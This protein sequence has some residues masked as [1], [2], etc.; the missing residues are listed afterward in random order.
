MR[1]DFKLE[2]K[3]AIGQRVGG[4]CS[5][6]TCRAATSGPQDD[7]AKPVNIGVA[8]H[9]SAASSG[10]PRFDPSLTPEERA[11]A[12][13]GIWLCQS[14]AKLV[15]NDE[16]RFTASL[17]GQWKVQAE[18]SAHRVLGERPSRHP[19]V[20][21]AILIQ[22]RGAIQ[23]SGPNAVVLGPNAIQINGPIVTADGGR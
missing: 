5:N 2:V 7:P 8:A 10:G 11:S 4:L 19:S 13:N 20:N 23:I 6:P 3:R 22:G 21:T 16:N 18:T 9:I 1:D 12:T 15:D 14:C 17:L